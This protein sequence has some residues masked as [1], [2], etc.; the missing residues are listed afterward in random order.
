M[1]K[2]ENTKKLEVL[3]NCCKKKIRVENG[4]V[5]EGV[6]SVQADWGYFSGKD[7]EIHKF[8]ICEQCYEKWVSQFKIPIE[9]V[10]KNE[11]L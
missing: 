5:M 1:R 10:S 7:G 6:L 8:D 4:I 11:M 9:V 2:N 3:C